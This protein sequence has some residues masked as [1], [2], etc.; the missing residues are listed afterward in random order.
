MY[1]AHEAVMGGGGGWHKASVMGGGGDL[2]QHMHG[3]LSV[4]DNQSAV[5]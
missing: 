2:T 5:D 4:W 3:D 1:Q